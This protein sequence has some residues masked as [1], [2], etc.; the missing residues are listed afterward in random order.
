MHVAFAAVLLGITQ[1]ALTGSTNRW[2]ESQDLRRAS[3]MTREEWQRAAK[4]AVGGVSERWHRDD[5]VGPYSGASY[6]FDKEASNFHLDGSATQRSGQKAIRESGLTNRWDGETRSKAYANLGEWKAPTD[7]VQS[8]RD[9]TFTDSKPNADSGDTGIW[10]HR[11]PLP[12]SGGSNSWDRA[13]EESLGST[14]STEEW[15]RAPHQATGGR[16]ESW[17]RDTT[18]RRSGVSSTFNKE[19]EGSLLAGTTTQ[20]GAQNVKRTSGLTATW[21]ART[22]ARALAAIEEWVAPTYVTRSGRSVTLTGAK[23]SAGNGHIDAWT[24][25]SPLSESGQS[26]RWSRDRTGRQSSVMSREEWWRAARHV[27]AGASELWGRGEID[28]YSGA[29]ST[30]NKGRRESE[31]AG[32]INEWNT[33]NEGR[34]SGLTAT[35]NAKTTAMA[36]ATLEEWTAPT[37]VFNSGKSVAFTETKFSDSGDTNS[38]IRPSILP[39]LGH[40]SRWGSPHKESL[41]SV[42]N[43]EEWWTA[44]RQAT[45]GNEELWDRNGAD[46]YSG[47]SSTFNKEGEESLL[48]GTTTQWGAQNV[49]RASGLTATWNARTTA[50]ALA[51]IEEWVAPTYVTRSGRSVTLTGAKASAGNGHIDA[52]T[53]QSP[54]SESGHSSRWSRDRTGRQSSVMSREEWWRAARHVAAGASEL[55]GRGEINRY[56]GASSTFN[57]GRRESKLAGSINEWNTNNEGRASGLTAT[58]NAKTTAMALATLE[59]WTAPTRVFNSGKSVAFT[60]TK[61]FDSGDTSS[62]IRPSI[63]PELGHS[64]RWGSPHKESLSSVTNAEE[65]WTATRQATSGNEE[66]WDRNGADRYFGVSSTFNKEGEESL[67]AGTTTQWGA[68]NVKRTSGLTATWNARTTARALAAIEEWVAPTYVTR[69]GRSVTLT[70]AEASAGN[71]HIDAWT[72]QSPLSESGHSSRWSRDRTGRLSS[73]TGKEEWWEA[74][75]RANKGKSNMW[76]GHN[77]DLYSGRAAVYHKETSKTQLTGS[78]NQWGTQDVRRASGTTATWNA[79]AP[80]MAYATLE[81]WTAPGGVI[82]SGSSTVFADAGYDFSGLQWKYYHSNSGRFC[83]DCIQRNPRC[84]ATTH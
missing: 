84:V 1:S 55:W 69:S 46:R 50:R 30:F 47:V 14:W 38:W 37:R 73:V 32:S 63:L 59:E 9:A 68:Q 78:T 31:L 28:R 41:S 2:D 3:K 60:E 26:S 12:G 10:T 17:G 13:H 66:L 83:V 53:H 22:T 75:S 81:E 65:W 44:T 23:A 51:A 8:G 70:G 29:S 25:Q 49:K 71:G 18:E 7:I 11:S 80:E 72:H 52:W 58:W 20:W 74:A 48:A 67:L 6:A 40:S 79:R 24:H 54:L 57:K 39:E 35:W 61:F 77:I 34:A 56:S 27:A 82:Q 4:H 42:T 45:S 15:R 21:N 36:L 43:A 33:N 5:D 64:S 16:E 19:G 62:W 76:E